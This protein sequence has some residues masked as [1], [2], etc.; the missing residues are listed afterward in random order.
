VSDVISS[1]PQTVA[2]TVT[3][4]EGAPGATAWKVDGSSVTQP[5]SGTVAVSNLP[6]TQPVS[7]TVTAN[8]GTN[9]NT[10][11]LA[12]EAGHL[13][14]IDTSTAA[15]ATSANQTNGNQKTQVTNFPATQPVSIASM[16]STPVTGTFW[17]ATQPVSGTVGISGTVPVSLA[18]APSTPVTGTFWQATQPVS[19][20]VTANAG[21]G[22]MAVSLASAPTTP[23]TGTFWQSTQPVSGTV[24]VSNLPTTQ[25]VSAAGLPLPAGAA[26]EA[27]GNLEGVFNLL[28]E[29]LRE[30]K[31]QS[32]L[33]QDG[34]GI[35]HDVDDLRMETDSTYDS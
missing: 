23:V 11:A 30:L 13:A 31:L 34:L 35:A 4:V 27:T 2:G 29:I 5:V 28:S 24:A 9:L 22:T 7:G 14:A 17:Q 15:G 25:P 16:P 32:A 6:G 26:L 1:A 20:T 3:A 19:G 10:S 33:L 18:S 12:L 8:A 21:S